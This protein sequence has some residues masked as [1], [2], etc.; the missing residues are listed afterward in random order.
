[1]R[2]A[3]E[4]WA[5]VFTANPLLFGGRFSRS[6]SSLVSTRPSI[7]DQNE[8]FSG[9]SRLAVFSVTTKPRPSLPPLFEMLWLTIPMASPLRLN[10][11]PPKLPVL[12]TASVWKNSASGMAR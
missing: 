11:G 6:A 12:I 10:M 7:P 4:P 3:G 9:N 1:M 8:R 5:T 2:S